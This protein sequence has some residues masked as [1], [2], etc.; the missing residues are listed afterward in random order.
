MDINKLS[1]GV[2]NSGSK[3]EFMND[4]QK[5]DDQE[6]KYIFHKVLMGETLLLLPDNMAFLPDSK[7][8]KQGFK[9]SS[10]CDFVRIPGV[11]KAEI[12]RL[13]R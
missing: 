2:E 9:V 4:Q 8:R 13:N 3:R 5:F 6:K 10:G 7:K 1:V 12:Q 11:E